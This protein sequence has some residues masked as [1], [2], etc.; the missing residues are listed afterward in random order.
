MKSNL[1]ILPLAFILF[2]VSFIAE[3]SYGQGAPLPL[4]ELQKT[5]L[6]KSLDEA[7]Q[8]PAQVYRLNLTK[9][10][11]TDLPPEI[12][13]LTNLQYLNVSKNSISSIP[14]EIGKLKNLQWLILEDNNIASL[15]SELSELSKLETLDLDGNSSL[16]V[17]GA[18][19]IASKMAFFK[20]IKYE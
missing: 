10:D 3:N 19:Q 11:I 12:G 2:A 9:Q 1:H 15:P 16:D 13:T 17:D 18:F 5:T 7:F 14:P 4:P 8:N 20:R 6:Y